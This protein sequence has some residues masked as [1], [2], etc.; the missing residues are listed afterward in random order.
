M[1]STMNMLFRF[2][3]HINW[4]IWIDLVRIHTSIDIALL[5]FS[6]KPPAYLFVIEPTKQL[7]IWMTNVSNL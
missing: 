6:F 3:G 1:V 5:C 4:E 2:T 7:D